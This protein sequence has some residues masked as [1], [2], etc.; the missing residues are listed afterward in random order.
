[1]SSVIV[2]V[3]LLLLLPCFA[4]NGCLRLSQKL[5]QSDSHCIAFLPEKFIRRSH[6]S[7]KSE[8]RKPETSIDS[9]PIR[10]TR[11]IRVASDGV[12]GP[13]WLRSFQVDPKRG[14]IVA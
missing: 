14:M 2:P 4:A 10:F 6:G 8:R 3:L 5:S 11:V 12:D 13:S 9:D 1:M 7:V